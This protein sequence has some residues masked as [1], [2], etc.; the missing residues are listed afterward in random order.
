MQRF[1]SSY[2]TINLLRNGGWDFIGTTD[3][4][5][6]DP[7]FWSFTNL[8]PEEDTQ[9]SAQNFFKVED[10]VLSITLHSPS[11]SILTQALNYLGTFDFVTPLGP[12][13]RSSQPSGYQVDRQQVM[14]AGE[15]T[16][17]FDFTGTAQVR[18]HLVQSTTIVTSADQR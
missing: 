8:V 16:V 9:N 5:A 1:A 4:G 17:A 18:V 10:N 14:P 6:P 15:Y 11:A 7:H 13:V 3:G 12:G 2:N